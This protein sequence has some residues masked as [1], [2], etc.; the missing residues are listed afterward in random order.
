MGV[1]CDI[2]VLL[3][4]HINNAI[5]GTMTAERD[6]KRD[7]D[8]MAMSFQLGM[9]NSILRAEGYHALIEVASRNPATRCDAADTSAAQHLLLF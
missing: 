4:Q 3:R 7:D 2:A 9:G 5:E 6:A 1:G 8:V